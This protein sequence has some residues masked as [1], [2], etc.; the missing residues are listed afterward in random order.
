MVYKL[1]P[2]TNGKWKETI[3]HLFYG[4]EGENSLGRVVFYATGNLYGTT[5]Y[6]GNRTA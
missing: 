6:G 5:D 3:V 2:A 1:A 4:A